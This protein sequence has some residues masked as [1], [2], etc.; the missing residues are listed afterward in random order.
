MDLKSPLL[1]KWNDR[2]AGRK[3]VTQGMGRKGKHPE[4]TK[5]RALDQPFGGWCSAFSICQGAFCGAIGSI[6]D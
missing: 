6:D 4:H 3:A 1:S 2:Q 5:R